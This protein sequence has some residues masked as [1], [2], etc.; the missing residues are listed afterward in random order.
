MTEEA[1]HPN[2]FPPAIPETKSRK[3]RAKPKKAK[4]MNTTTKKTAPV[5][6]E[7]TKPAAPSGRQA[8]AE[9]VK[10][11][12]SAGAAT[13]ARRPSVK[14]VAEK[15]VAT[16]K[17]A[18]KT[19]TAPAK[20]TASKAPAAPA[21]KVAVKKATPAAKKPAKPAAPAHRI[22]YKAGA[23]VKVQRKNGE[24]K[25]FV[26]KVFTKKTGTFIEVNIG[27]KQ[28]PI[29]HQARPAAVRGF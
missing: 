6:T 18:A 20:K 11:M 25:G 1:I 28:V 7:A 5:K 29:L 24:F 12:K 15:V 17:A 2:L 23:R 27:T 8:L 9:S 3:R 13:P 22:D 10:Q 19:P 21:K 16:T 14:T 26:T 4:K